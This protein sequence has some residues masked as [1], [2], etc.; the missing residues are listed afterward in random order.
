MGILSAEMLAHLRG[1]VVIHDIFEIDLVEIVGPWVKNR[2]A[3]V[4]DPLCAIL[5]NVVPDEL[6]VSL[7]G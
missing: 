7:V 5:H 2:E 6:K 1:E 4:L 3:L